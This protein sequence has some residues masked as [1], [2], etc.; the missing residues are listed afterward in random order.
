[1]ISF[2]LYDVVKE[3]LCGYVFESEEVD[4]GVP[5]HMGS[6]T[7][8]AKLQRARK[9]PRELRSL[10]EDDN[11]APNW[12]TSKFQT[13]SLVLSTRP[14]RPPATRCRKKE[15]RGSGDDGGRKV[16]RGAAL[17]PRHGESFPVRTLICVG[18]VHSQVVCAPQLCTTT[19]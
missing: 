6:L 18:S 5:A 3:F 9:T 15:R 7:K 16:P 14:H 19:P 10:T 17:T 4:D 13:A 1:M 11:A 12:L 2:Y 8:E